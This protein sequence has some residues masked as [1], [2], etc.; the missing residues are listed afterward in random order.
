MVWWCFYV[1]CL[2]V[3][4]RH[5]WRCLWILR[6]PSSYRHLKTWGRPVSSR[7][8]R[9]KMKPLE[10]AKRG[11]GSLQSSSQGCQMRM[12]E[13]CTS[14][15]N[16]S[17]FEYNDRKHLDYSLQC[18]F[19]WKSYKTFGQSTSTCVD[20]TEQ[21]RIS[22]SYLL[23]DHIWQHWFCTCRK[24]TVWSP[25][26]CARHPWMW[27]VKLIRLLLLMLLNTCLLQFNYICGILI[28]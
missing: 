24:E 28:L 18:N 20:C 5:G 23:Q 14:S 3:R 4:Y 10:G 13:V 6:I 16:V 11:N 9:N 19:T 15:W 22:L 12:F 8:Q 21:H 1:S 27:D 2:S 7:P 17:C 25:A 26:W